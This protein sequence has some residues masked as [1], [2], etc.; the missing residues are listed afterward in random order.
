MCVQVG[1]LLLLM[2]FDVTGA[3]LELLLG[4]MAAITVASGVE[5]AQRAH[6]DT[7]PLA[8]PAT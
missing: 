2:T 5:V 6:R 1:T 3:S 4:A 7:A 8:A